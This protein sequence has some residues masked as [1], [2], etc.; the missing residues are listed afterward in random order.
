M[1]D[2][3]IAANVQRYLF[4]TD[5]PPGSGEILEDL[6]TSSSAWIENEIGGNLLSASITETRNGDGGTRMLLWHSHTWRPGAPPT[7]ITSVHVDG[8]AIPARAAVS[9]SNT[10]PEGYA[11][12][13]DGIDLV[14]Y[15]FTSGLRNVVIVYTHGYAAVPTD[16]EQATI[17]HVALRYMDRARSGLVSVSGG[18][19]SATYGTAGTFAYIE[20]VLQKYRVVGVG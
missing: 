1:A 4:G 2:F 12:S 14:G 10:N 20:S 5:A 17:E 13:E 8:T 15:T 19:E 11:F 16:I 7:S 6:V 9:S 18:L 3:T